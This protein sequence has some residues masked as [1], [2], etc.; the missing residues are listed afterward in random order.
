[1]SWVFDAGAILAGVASLL[2]AWWARKAKQQTNGPITR[3]NDTLGVVLDSV[4]SVGH[5]I[6]E[7][8]ADMGR[9]D[10]RL[11]QEVA[12]LRQRLD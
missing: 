10:E 9:M 4:R 6:G 2:A 7:V 5:Q 12:D 3:A 1:M 8:R 11:T